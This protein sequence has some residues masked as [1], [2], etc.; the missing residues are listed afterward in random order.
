VNKNR[1]RF[2]PLR[3]SN[4]EIPEFGNSEVQNLF[5]PPFC[6]DLSAWYVNFDG[7]DLLC[8]IVCSLALKKKRYL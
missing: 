6:V 1:L 5:F 8:S 4:S 2:L 7:P 3:Y